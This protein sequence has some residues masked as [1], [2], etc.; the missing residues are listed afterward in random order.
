MQNSFLGTNLT[1]YIKS[2]WINLETLKD[3]KEGMNT[4]RSVRCP[5]V[6]MLDIVKISFPQINW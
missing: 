6:G 3:V 5:Q 1:R 4:W 2:L